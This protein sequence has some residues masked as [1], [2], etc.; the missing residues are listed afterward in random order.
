[1]AQ[2][3][4]IDQNPLLIIPRF[5][6]SSNPNLKFLGVSMLCQVHSDAWSNTW[7][8]ENL[9]SAVVEALESRDKTVQRKTLELLYRMLTLDNAENIIERLVHAFYE[10]QELE[11][12]VDVHSYNEEESKGE[13][14]PG[15]EEGRS[16]RMP[17]Q[18]E[19][20][21]LQILDALDRFATSEEQFLTQIFGLLDNG[22]SVVTLQTAERILYIFDQG[23][24]STSIDKEKLRRIGVEK[25]I[26]ILVDKDYSLS[27]QSRVSLPSVPA[28]SVLAYVVL[29]ILGEYASD[30]I[31]GL[32]LSSVL[33]TL[34]R[35]ILKNNQVLGYTL[36]AM[37]KVALKSAPTPVPTTITDLVRRQTGAFSRQAKLNSSASHLLCG[38]IASP[39]LLRYPLSAAFDVEQ[40]AQEFLMVAELVS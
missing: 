19:K 16:S 21:L 34:A 1:M 11:T 18:R 4:D 14:V 36:K 30:D 15:N 39:S 5:A 12:G 25:A 24:Q 13:I 8:S 32:P 31:Q 2:S 40:R 26:K 27:Q 23:C 35:C 3:R 7:W 22:G 6:A 17:S 20:L 10:E 38:V 33:L 29:W 37:V 9:L 28:H